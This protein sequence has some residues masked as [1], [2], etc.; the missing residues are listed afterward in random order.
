M[1]KNALKWANKRF[2]TIYSNN[3]ICRIKNF[4]KKNYKKIMYKIFETTA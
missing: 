1:R 2:P 4:T 3:N